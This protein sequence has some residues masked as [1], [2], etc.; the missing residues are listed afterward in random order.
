MGMSIHNNE[1]EYLKIT[2]DAFNVYYHQAQVIGVARSDYVFNTFSSFFLM[3]V[4]SIE[5]GRLHPKLVGHVKLRQW[6]YSYRKVKKR[7]AHVLVNHK[8]GIMMHRYTLDINSPIVITFFPGFSRAADV[9]EHE[10]CVVVVSKAYD[11][12]YT[13]LSIHFA[14]DFSKIRVM[15]D[16]LSKIIHKPV[17]FDVFEFRPVRAEFYVRYDYSRERDV[18]KALHALYTKFGYEEMVW[19]QKGDGAGDGDD[20]IYLHRVH[21]IYDDLKLS[22]KTYRR[23]NYHH[24]PKS[25][26]DQPK[27]EITVYFAENDTIADV[28]D[29]IDKT[30]RFFASFIKF[31][32]QSYYSQSSTGDNCS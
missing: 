26:R 30:L 16:V 12:S 31:A 10:K 19:R 20:V 14:D 18:S 3:L 17:N 8:Y 27:L 9:R 4:R 7:K 2:D 1:N 6:E 21:L 29:K 5:S 28:N 24:P 32:F 25:W 22:I 23:R 15:L 13:L 11:T